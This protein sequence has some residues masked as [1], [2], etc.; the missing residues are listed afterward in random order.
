[1]NTGHS[2]S[3][4]T[5]GANTSVEFEAICGRFEAAWNSGQ[6]P[7]IND[8]LEI[9]PPL[10]NS[11]S[12]QDLLIELAMIDM[13]R[14]WR[15]AAEAVPPSMLPDRPAAA[16]GEPTAI[17]NRPRLEDY[18]ARF[19][20]LGPLDLLP[21]DLVA[22][23][24][25]VRHR[26]GDRP[27]HAEYLAR[28]GAKRPALA[29]LLSKV[30][31]QSGPSEGSVATKVAL[32]V[33]RGPHSGKAFTFERHDSFVVGRGTKAHFRLPKKDPFFSRYHFIVEVNPPHCLL[34]DLDSTNGTRINNSRITRKHLSHGDKIRAGKT[35]LLVEFIPPPTKTE[36]AASPP[37]LPLAVS[38]KTADPGSES[39]ESH[40]LRRP[41]PDVE[42]ANRRAKQEAPVAPEIP[43]YEILRPLGEGGMGIVYLAKRAQDRSQV[44]LKLIRPA[45]AASEQEVDLFL[46]EA[47]ILR[48]LRHP[49]IVLFQ[50]MGHQDDH[51]YFAMEYVP[52]SDG[53]R[54]LRT[55]GP[56]A[57][58]RAVA[59]AC[60]AL[61]A[62]QYAHGQGFVHRDVKPANLL[63]TGQADNEICKLADFG[64]A[65]AY[66]ASP[67]SGLTMIGDVGGT[68][69]Y[70]PPEQV[71]H[72]R[73]AKPPADQYAVAATLYRL[74]TGHY[75]FDLDDDSNEQRLMKIL[76]EEPIPLI[77]RRPD[78]PAGLCKAI[79]R[80][81]EKEAKDRFTDAAEFR[82]ALLTFAAHG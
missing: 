36:D 12:P 52:G 21:D 24:Y 57:I 77:H 75:L 46:R 64:L 81:L 16:P 20:D 48:Q 76:C 26:W 32:K 31:A 80:A 43:G 72:Y 22:H 40:H 47:D 61:E 3:G 67:M 8:F 39:T 14:R 58:A 29:Q 54:L 68:L 13:E 50:E 15:S 45:V 28:F 10:G 71:T 23:E 30:D 73:D 56:L 55:H 62:L 79:H 60:Q 33:V 65:R 17:P 51:L 18:V 74:L 82:D 4:E 1:M 41:A 44:A 59:L 25:R 49:H 42:M 70:M 38:R 27:R 9:E 5:G 2:R 7:S 6:R 35:V 69:P 11:L 78:A 34:V 19:D 66:Q 37:P 53:S 63:V